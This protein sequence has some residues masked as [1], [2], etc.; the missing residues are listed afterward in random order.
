MEKER[1]A[2]D[3]S[4]VEMYYYMGWMPDRYYYQSNG[5]PAWENFRDQ[6]DQIYERLL[7]QKEGFNDLHIT[8]EVKID[9]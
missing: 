3:S 6:K 2:T 5:R 8:S 1:A 4:K 7:D 9:K